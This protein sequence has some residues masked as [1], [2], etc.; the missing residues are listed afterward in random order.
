M[1]I[2]VY[3]KLK[4]KEIVGMCQGKQTLKGYKGLTEDEAGLIFGI[5][6]I[7]GNNFILKHPNMFIV[8]EKD[9]FLDIKLK[10]DI[11]V[12]LEKLM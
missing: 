8:V 10:E 5:F 3:Y 2:S 9:E 11:R 6:T 12:S 1:K 7:D 4:T